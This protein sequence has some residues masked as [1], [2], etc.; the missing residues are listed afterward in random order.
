LGVLAERTYDEAVLPLAPGTA[1]A[2]CS[3]GVEESRNAGAE[4]LGGERVQKVLSKLAGASAVEIAQGLLQAVR[5]HAG[6]AEASDD[7]TIV[8]LKRVE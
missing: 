7:R 3:D 8:V 2:F 4:E 6:P 1:V 5:R